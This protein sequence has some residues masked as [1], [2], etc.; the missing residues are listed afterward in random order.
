MVKSSVIKMLF[1]VL[2]TL[3]L[4]SCSN[5]QGV[6]KQVDV[7]ITVN[8]PKSDVFTVKG[9]NQTSNPLATYDVPITKVTVV[10]KSGTTQVMRQDFTSLSNISFTLENPGNYTIELYAYGT[11]NSQ[12]V[13]IFYA[14][15]DV[16]L[17]Y[18]ANALQMDGIFFK[19]T[20]EFS[21]KMS[22]T[23]SSNW[24]VTYAKLTMTKNTDGSKLEYDVTTEMAA[25][26]TDFSKLFEVDP[27]IYKLS[28]SLKLKNKNNGAEYSYGTSDELYRIFYP[29]LTEK[30]DL[31]INEVDGNVVVTVSELK[32]TLPFVPSVQNLTY[33]YHAL[34]K[35]LTLRW[36]YPYLD[37][38]TKFQIFRKLSNKNGLELIGETTSTTYEITLGSD[39]VVVENL[40]YF[41]INVVKDGKESGIKEISV[42]IVLIYSPAQN[43]IINRTTPINV[44]ATKD[45]RFSKAELYVNGTKISETTSRPFNFQLDTTYYYD[46]L[47][48]IS[49]VVKDSSGNKLVEDSKQVVIQNWQKNY[50]SNTYFSD[51]IEG[52][53]GNFVIIARTDDKLEVLKADKNGQLIWRKSFSDVG[54][55]SSS[56]YLIAKADGGY[57]ICGYKSISGRG[58]DGVV[59]KIDENGNKLWE[60]TYG[61][62]S[63]DY[64][65][66][67]TR[68]TDGNYLLAG[69]T[70]ESQSKGWLIEIDK[71]G[72]IISETKLSDVRSLS[73]A[74]EAR[75][76]DILLGGQYYYNYYYAWFGVMGSNKSIKWSWT[77]S[78]SDFPSTYDVLD[79]GDGFIFRIASSYYLY[80]HRIL[81]YNYSGQFLWEYSWGSYMVWGAITYTSDNAIIITGRPGNSVSDKPTMFK[82]MNSNTGVTTIWSATFNVG[83][84]I[85]KVIECSDGD[86]A[87]IGDNFVFRRKANGDLYY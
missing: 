8:V 22:A 50:G 36:D 81:K 45:S 41:G 23:V 85:R 19:S 62:T 74:K 5:P 32:V 75:N 31:L 69:Q 28:F 34:N 27:G 56:R 54:F 10:V 68:K 30:Y 7:S 49:V 44:A 78:S 73:I 51:I 35:K 38:K 46:N 57:L 2:I 29:S 43:A 33:S 52:S 65:Y 47:H 84:E 1:I 61:A 17:N 37:D 42:P 25:S 79:V 24:N 53:N 64:I 66:S 12:L 48:T 15:K 83:Y 77:S 70:Y 18:G 21:A 63:D 71:D 11:I 55:N 13:G 20:L 59:F 40:E 14:T 80:N 87:G 9:V 16:T 6:K 72:N 60:K 58:F 76:G 26:P 4:F 86:L 82:I 3:Y 39:P 67:I